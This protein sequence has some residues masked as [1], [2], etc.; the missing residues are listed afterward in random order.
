MP[1]SRELVPTN[2]E[3]ILGKWPEKEENNHDTT[4]RKKK[5]TETDLALP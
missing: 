2:W 3:E 1:N 5:T 4:E